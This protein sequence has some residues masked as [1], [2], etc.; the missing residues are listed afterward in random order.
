MSNTRRGFLSGILAIGAAPAIV[1]ADSLMK[2]VVPTWNPL[3]FGDMVWRPD[4]V[5]TME[6][7]RD[8][9]LFNGDVVVWG[10]RS[11]TAIRYARQGEFSE[12]L[13]QSIVLTPNQHGRGLISPIIWTPINTPTLK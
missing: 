13:S 2:I 9:T 6:L 11:P 12:S 3:C 7:A 8:K 1:K 5:K 4:M 10:H